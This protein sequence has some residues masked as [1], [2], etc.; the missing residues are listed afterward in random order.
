MINI[1]RLISIFAAA[2][3]GSGQRRGATRERS[4]SDKGRLLLACKFDLSRAQ[5]LM[6][7]LYFFFGLVLGFLWVWSVYEIVKH[8]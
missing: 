6:I 3:R 7:P 2:S 1:S 4:K 5:S 8:R